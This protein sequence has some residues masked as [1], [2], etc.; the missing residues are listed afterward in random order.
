[1]GYAKLE[2]GKAGW[3]HQQLQLALGSGIRGIWEEREEDGDENGFHIRLQN[4]KSRGE[5]GKHH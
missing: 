4:L 3:S 1:M 5:H 2:P